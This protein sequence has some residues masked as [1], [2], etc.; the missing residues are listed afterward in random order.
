[1]NWNEQLHTGK[2]YDPTVSEMTDLQ[3]QC[4]EML[5]D[6]NHSRPSEESKRQMLLKQM[7]A[8]IGEGCH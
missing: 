6:F 3:T 7:L 4:L 8:E 1:M 5:Y 2:I